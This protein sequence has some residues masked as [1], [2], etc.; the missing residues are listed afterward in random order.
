VKRIR[1]RRHSLPV[2]MV[3]TLVGLVILT[4]AAI[5]IPAIY[6]LRNQSE[7]FAQL[8]LEQGG[9]TALAL[10]SQQRSRL[11]SLALL[12]AQRPSLHSL[13]RA[14]RPQ[15]L[16]SY[17]LE[18]QRGAGLELLLV[19]DAEEQ[20]ILNRQGQLAARACALG[21]D[22]TT[23]LPGADGGVQGWILAE[24]TLPAGSVGGRVVTGQPLNQAYARELAKQADLD[25]VLYLDGEFLASS[26]EAVEESNRS[27]NWRLPEGREARLILGA[28]TYFFHRLAEEG[29][30]LELVLLFPA[31]G[32][33]S[34]QGVVTRVAGWGILLVILLGSALGIA[35][36]RQISRPLER[37]RAAAEGL[38]MGDLVSPV[39]ARTDLVEVRQVAQGLEEA[40]RALQHSL[41]QLQREKAWA[42]HLLD[43]VVEGILTIDRTGRINFFSSGAEKITGWKAE[44]VLG[45][46]LDEVFRV[47]DEKAVFSQ[48]IPAPGGRQKIPVLLEGG[49]QRMLSVTG[50][51]L[52]PPEA[53]R[54]QAVL[55]LRDVSDEE[56]VRKLLGDFLANI[57]HE[58]RTPLSAL[59]A[60]IELLMDQLPELS[61]E[62]LGQLLGS[63]HLGI[64]S[65]QTLIDN[66]LEGASIE[67]GR[68]RV[69]PRE[70]AVEEI[71]QQAVGTMQPLAEKYGQ[72]IALELAPE[73]PPVWAD[74]RRTLQVLV[75]LLSNAIKWG[76][77]GGVVTVSAK[78]EKGNV[79]VYVADQGPGIPPG[80]QE[81][82]FMRFDR[83]RV[84]EGRG[85]YGAGLGLSVVKAVVEA[86]GGQVGAGSRE[87]QGAVFWFTLPL[88]VEQA[89]GRV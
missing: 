81:D 72:S 80:M 60:S 65:L 24:Q 79:W 66:L 71:L 35:R 53:G 70:A 87:G 86:Q 34:L 32:V 14:G 47:A 39:D 64:L 7:R 73:L 67:A 48:R 51:R 88:A 4:A 9:R 8:S 11:G 59:G 84:R 68:F 62:E 42:E 23:F 13:L 3:I 55:V 5:G 45:R 83:A 2:Q 27:G 85:E 58:F 41:E 38:R 36:A 12:T 40:R 49:R 46:N 43:A 78:A 44:T 20:P 63:I 33:A 10:I 54:A 16:E 37:L 74:Q 18:L 52:A 56:A 6:Y 19:C 61:S 30:G 75:N 76:P 15:E 69:Y 26:L 82:L 22:A 77:E 29:S 17:L 89:E 25:I 57:S 28:E 21:R 31:G 50:G 1:F